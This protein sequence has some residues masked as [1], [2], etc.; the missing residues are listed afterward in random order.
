MPLK[1]TKQLLSCR[2]FFGRILLFESRQNF[3]QAGSD[4]GL[5]F[6]PQLRR[7][8]IVSLRDASG[9]GGDWTFYS[10]E[11]IRELVSLLF[12][13]GSSL[14]AWWKNNSFTQAALAGDEVKNSIK[15]NKEV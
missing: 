14:W 15:A 5:G 4:K 11:Q 1:N 10:D 9:D 2:S 7:N 13:V 8:A 6:F 12:T 3:H